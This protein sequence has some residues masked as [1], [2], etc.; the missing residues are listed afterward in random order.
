MEYGQ[1]AGNSSI[2]ALIHRCF[3]FIDDKDRKEF[4]GKFCRQPHDSDQIMHTFRELILGAYLNSHGFTGKYEYKIGAKTPD[5]CLLNR[6]NTIK[7]IIELLNFHIDEATNQYIMEQRKT[8]QVVVYWQDANKN[9]LERLLSRIQQKIDQYAA[10]VSESKI[11]Y[12]IA[13]FTHFEVVID[14]NKGLL[15]RL[16]NEEP[17]LFNKY[18]ELSGVVFF[19]EISGK[20]YF[21][22]AK[23]PRAIRQICIPEGIFP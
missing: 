8:T 22:Y 21:R 18:N 19:E 14:F 4:L 23:N 5:W 9:N 13:I 3:E 10:L 17:G 20:Y 7:S 6:D 2:D 1:I 16:M 12:V 11:S 15:P